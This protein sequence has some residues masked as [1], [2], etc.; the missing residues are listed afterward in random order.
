M[1]KKKDK[2]RHEMN[3]VGGKTGLQLEMNKGGASVE[4]S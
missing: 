1:K 2:A 4:K 3:L